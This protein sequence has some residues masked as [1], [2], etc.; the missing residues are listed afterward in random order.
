MAHKISLDCTP[1]GNTDG[2]LDAYQYQRIGRS[3]RIRRG[4]ALLNEDESGDRSE[5]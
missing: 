5:E 3:R 2:L 1:A 4:M